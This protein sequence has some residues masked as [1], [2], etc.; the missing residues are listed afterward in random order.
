MKWMELIKVQTAKPIIAAKLLSYTE[1]CS[2]C[3][4]LLEAK[5]FRHASVDD[6]SLCLRWDTDRPEPQGSSVGLYLSSSLKQYG[7][8]DHS[9]WIEQEGQG[10][11]RA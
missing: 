4:G 11:E 5:V 9:V 2:Q 7:L 1:G 10:E 6:C 3:R 8:V